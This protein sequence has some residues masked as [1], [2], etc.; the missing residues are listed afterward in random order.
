ML[1]NFSKTDNIIQSKMMDNIYE[2]TLKSLSLIENNTNTI[3]N[4]IHF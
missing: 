3:V 1:T 2:V 4:S